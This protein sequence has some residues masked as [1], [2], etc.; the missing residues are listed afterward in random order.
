M[1]KKLIAS[2]M[3]LAMAGG[4]GLAN[5]DV[6][7]Y[8]QIDL[9]IL[10]TDSDAPGFQ[11]DVNMKS[12][13]SA[14][15]VK[16][17]EDLGNGLSAFFKLEYEADIANGGDFGTGRDQFVGFGMEDFGKL[18]FGTT[19]T[20][21]KSPGSKIDP[22]YR[23]PLQSRDVGLQSNLHSGK[24]DQGQGRGT[25]MIR[26]DSPTMAGFGL[27]VAY[28]LAENK[29][30]PGPPPDDDV[31]SAGVDYKG[32]N[33]YAAASYITTQQSED[34]AA[35]QFL[36]RY[37]MG[38]FSVHGIYEY[39][40]G[41]ITAQA[42]NG[43]GGSL[44]RNGEAN[45]TGADVYSLGATYTIGNNLIGADYGHRDSSDGVDGVAG[46]GDDIEE[47][48]VWRIAAYHSFSKRT[49]VYAGYANTDYNNKGEDDRFAVGVRHNF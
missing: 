19:S 30:L 44:P 29:N 41:L 23:T 18:T 1:N 45:D 20:A 2:A 35:A 47:Y 6:K 36:V 17:E 3:G 16:G 9:S 49:R 8:G 10:A 43:F 4:M 32:G 15:G 37:D 28:Q 39:D 40:D 42:N 34:N 46:G 48:D 31:V 11:D 26:Y 5:A 21:Y 24:G 33:L 12:Q 13:N 38:D 7:L 25:N 22:F 14:L 27:T